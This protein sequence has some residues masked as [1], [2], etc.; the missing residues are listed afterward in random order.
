MRLSVRRVAFLRSG[1]ISKTLFLSAIVVAPLLQALGSLDAQTT[2][3]ALGERR[4]EYREALAE[5][6]A[7]QSAFRVVEQRFSVALA[8]A[9]RARRSGDED[10]Q[11]R[12]LAEAL[13]RSLPVG[14]RDRR[15]RET[16]ERL[17]EAR[18]VLIDVI[19]IQLTELLGA[20]SAAGPEE[21]EQL[22]ALW[23]DLNNE[24]QG[25]EADA[26]NPFRLDPLVLQDQVSFDPRD[27]PAERE[28]KAQLLER[29][30]ALAD[31]TVLYTDRQ[32]AALGDRLRQERQRRDFLAGVDRFGDTPPV[33][34]TRR[35]GDPPVQATDSTGAPVRPPTLEERIQQLQA[36]KQEAEAYRDR[37]LVQAERFRRF[38]RSRT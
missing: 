11:N 7:A 36:A 30:A 20:M 17:E 21:R 4:L 14:D 3:Q 6:E 34:P 28:A 29:M 9:D 24:R 38:T 13:E 23:R 8:E 31:S 10:A 25:L 32:I 27:G 37:L 15:V 5:H 22:D 18:S 1:A 19:T 2:E 16:A 12:A 26:E 35:P 33:V